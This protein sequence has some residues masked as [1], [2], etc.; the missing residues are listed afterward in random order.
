LVHASG[1]EDPEGRSVGLWRKERR[2]GLWL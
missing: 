2:A 1:A